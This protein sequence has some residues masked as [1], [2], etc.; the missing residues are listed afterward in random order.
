[1]CY[2][3]SIISSFNFWLYLVGIIGAL[4]IVKSQREKAIEYKKHYQAY[5]LKREKL[6]QELKE[7]KY[8]IKNTN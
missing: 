7:L 8:D 5:V 3:Y 4:I 6:E 2:F 1:M